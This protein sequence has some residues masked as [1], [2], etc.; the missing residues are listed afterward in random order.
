[1]ATSEI[2]PG[3]S[4][5]ESAVLYGLGMS[6]F[7]RGDNDVALDFM[8]RACADPEAPA[9][10][11]RNH[12]EMLDRQGQ[13]EAAEAAARLSV[14]LDPNCASAWETLGTILAQRGLFKES[15]NCYDRAVRIDP[16]FVQALNN[17]AVTLDRLGRLS[18]AEQCYRRALRVAPRAAEIQLNLATI[19]GELGRHREGLAIAR[20][21]LGRRPN[22]MKAHSLVTEFRAALKRRKSAPGGVKRRSPGTPTARQQ[23][24]RRYRGKRLSSPH[25]PCR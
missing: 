5:G 1:M 15:C 11:H 20:K 14:R 23:Q 16:K 24:V 4:Q 9:I 12:A 10:W 7:R 22:M 3:P 25:C 17:L 19:L 18:R 6:A 2:M 21:V 8:S 13:S